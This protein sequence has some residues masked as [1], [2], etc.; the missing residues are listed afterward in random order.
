MEADFFVFVVCTDRAQHKRTL[1]TT[2][3]R[4]LG[5][6]HGMNNALNCFAPPDPNAK[7]RTATGRDSYVFW[8]PRCTRTP[9]INKERWW[10]II[11]E[12]G[13]H[14]LDELDLSLLPL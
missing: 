12:M 4:D 5:G 11:D 2:A 10:Q 3:R 13:R 9:H 7:E 8:C 6:G 1:L 14:G